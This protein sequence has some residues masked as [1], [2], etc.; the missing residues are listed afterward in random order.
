MIY[1]IIYHALIRF[2]CTYEYHRRLEMFA[3]LIVELLFLIG[4]RM[5]LIEPMRLQV[6]H[7][8]RSV[9]LLE[10]C[11]QFRNHQIFLKIFL[12]EILNENI[13]V[14]W[15]TGEI[16]TNSPTFPFE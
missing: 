15:M 11:S 5:Y 9:L 13:S 6:D 2:V 12:I 4:Q 10:Q 1:D 8:V 14:I 16:F 3:Q 7:L